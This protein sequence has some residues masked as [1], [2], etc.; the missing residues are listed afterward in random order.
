M[1]R[2]RRHPAPIPPAWHVVA[3]LALLAAGCRFA[4]PAGQA[5]P[6][7]TSERLVEPALSAPVTLITDPNGIPHLQAA[8]LSDLYFAWGWVTAR[9]RL[10]QLEMTRLEARGR[11]HE[12]LGNSALRADGGAQLFRFGERAKAIW[13]RDRAN[14]DVRLALERYAAGINARIAEVREGR[15]PLP[16]EMTHLR[17]EPRDWRPEDS[18]MT[19]LG[20]GITLD[21]DLPEL[22]EAEDVRGHGLAWT[23]ARRRFEGRWIYDTIPD[24]AAA[25][26]WGEA[27]AV[28]PPRGGAGAALA[29]PLLAQARATLG[30]LRA[31]D[32]GEDSRAS[33]CMVVGAKRSASGFPLL[34]NDPHL[35]LLAPGYLHLLHVS[36][37]GQCEAIGAA[38]PG[39]PAIVS[40]RNRRCAWGVTALGAD[41]ADVMADSISRNGRRVLWHGHWV[42]IEAHPYRMTFRLLG[43]P[44]PVLG[45]LRR[46]TPEGPVMVFEPRH[47]RALSLRWSAFEDARISLSRLVGVERSN[48]A[49]ELAERYRSLV[50]PTINLMAADVAGDVRYQACGLIPR[51]LSDPGPGPLPGGGL[52]PWPGYIPAD[53]LPS[54]HV[55]PTRFAVNG[56]NRPLAHYPYV[57][58]R[59]D[60]AQDRAWRMAERLG[61]DASLTGADLASVQNDVHSRAAERFLPWLIAC[62]DSLR[63]S[64]DAREHAALDTLR[65]WDL[66]ARRSRVAPTL[67]RAWLG[68]LTRR[69]RTD[70]LPGLTLAALEGRAP[71]ALRAPGAESPERASLAAV[72]ALALALDTLA[73]RLGPDLS[74]WNWARAHQAHFRHE[75]A[76]RSR[77]R[78]PRWEPPL[79]PVDGDNST[80][81]VGPSRL[82]WSIEV[83]H[84]PVFRHVVDLGNPRWSWGVVPPGNAAGATDQLDRWANHGYVPLILDWSLLT[85]AGADRVTLAPR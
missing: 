27:H 12:W 18:V 83:S 42:P 49:G 20:L 34:A 48:S 23:V 3:A 52:A 26:M 82:P 28:A 78:D 47:G 19:L 7:E 6:A 58:P 77:G 76:A 63:D 67:Y 75:L 9:D 74:N 40:G 69:S 11:S 73:T 81:C 22:S 36:V 71:D 57:L 38:V 24:S 53:S 1:N 54:W 66:M 37:A 68:A 50:T 70:G 8:N 55:P 62:A 60:W 46:Y 84:A 51:R 13:E 2:S 35:S 30:A 72:R 16:P 15:S 61:G 41:V 14:P 5:P 39:L 79:T 17:C 59:F 80:P 33:D 43:I 45:Q 25:R 4:P 64:L 10:W 65:S 44:I 32:S 29:P 85:A 56:N 31:A 21:L